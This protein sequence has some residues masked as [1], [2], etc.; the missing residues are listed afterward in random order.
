V[1][2]KVVI[3][4]NR[5]SYEKYSCTLILNNS[6]RI[7]GLDVKSSHTNKCKDKNNWK[8]ET[9]KHKWVEKCRDGWAYT[10]TD[11]DESSIPSA[12][13]SFFKECNINHNGRIDRLPPQ[14][15]TLRD[16]L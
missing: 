4:I 16:L 2:L 9:H 12:I 14:L 8:A 13:N 1:N 6:F 15:T 10:P 7:R 5:F 3:T 11:I